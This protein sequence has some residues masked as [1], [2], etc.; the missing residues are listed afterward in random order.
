MFDNTA[1][2][3]RWKFEAI[4]NFWRQA[5]NFC[6][7]QFG[8]LGLSD[9]MMNASSLLE[10]LLFS[11]WRVRR[12]PWMVCYVSQHDLYIHGGFVKA[13]SCG[14]GRFIGCRYALFGDV[15]FGKRHGNRPCSFSLPVHSNVK[16]CLKI[17]TIFN[18]TLRHNFHTAYKKAANGTGVGKGLLPA[19]SLLEHP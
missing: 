7:S 15:F 2:D 1:W 3:I 19:F 11:A 16:I 18:A 4:P 9:K 5:S 6:W 10:K 13:K 17:M 14:F 12:W 8:Q